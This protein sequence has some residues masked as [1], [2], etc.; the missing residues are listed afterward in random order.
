VVTLRSALILVLMAGCAAGERPTHVHGTV[1]IDGEPL[2]DGFILFV[3]AEGTPGP[4]VSS[5]IKDGSFAISAEQSV[6]I[7]NHHVEIR[8]RRKT[9]KQI[10]A[11]PPAP[12]GTKID[13][14]V[15]AV[16]PRY[17]R[18]STLECEIKLGD[19]LLVFDLTTK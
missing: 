5:D 12:P 18:E 15:E 7:G 11:V 6:P 2:E 19:N 8:G 17:H 3:P 10:D 13:E 1:T 4:A 9:G 16:P 14:W